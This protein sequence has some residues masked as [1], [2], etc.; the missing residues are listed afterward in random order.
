[1]QKKSLKMALVDDISKIAASILP[2]IDGYCVDVSIR[3]ERG[4]SVVEVF[5]DTD[6]GVTADECAQVNRY[7]ASEIENQNLIPGRYR[8]EVSSPGLD[9]PLKLARQYKKN[10]GRRVK[11]VSL[12]AGSQT[13]S[14]G[15]LQAVTETTLTLATKEKQEQ[16]FALNEIREAYVLPQFK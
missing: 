10:I 15:I 12:S 9:R 11:I 4:G 3:G 2:S 6:R 5:V 1:L 13:A 14:E 16:S 8:L 7:V